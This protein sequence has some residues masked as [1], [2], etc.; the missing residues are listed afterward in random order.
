MGL[1]NILSHSTEILI[2]GLF[3]SLGMLVLE[4]VI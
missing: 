3:L 4:V 1:R 2:H